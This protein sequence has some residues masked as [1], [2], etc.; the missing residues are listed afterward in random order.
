M[1]ALVFAAELWA[2]RARRRSLAAD[3]APA[4]GSDDR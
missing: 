4:I 2:L 1:C 3:G